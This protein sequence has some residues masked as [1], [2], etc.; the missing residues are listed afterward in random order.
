ML[1][2][3]MVTK[4]FTKHLGNATPQHPN[5]LTPFPLVL[6][7]RKGRRKDQDGRKK[8][9]LPFPTNVTLLTTAVC[10]AKT[11]AQE[12]SRL[13]SPCL[14]SPAKQVCPQSRMTDN[15][16]IWIDHFQFLQFPKI[17]VWFKSQQMMRWRWKKEEK[18]EGWVACS[19]TKQKGK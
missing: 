3:I 10:T 15:Y 19:D 14:P 7:M 9:Y 16:W 6:N 4:M 1:T 12:T 5:V 13:E 8:S 18:A 11:P 17:S 2:L